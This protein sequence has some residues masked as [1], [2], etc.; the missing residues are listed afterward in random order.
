MTRTLGGSVELLD[1]ALSYTRG[2]LATVRDDVL[3]RP[4]P[5]EGWRLDDLLA[6]MEDALD[7]FTEAAGGA[8]VLRGGS[9]SRGQVAV[10]R[11]KA[12]ALLGAWARPAPGDVVIETATGSRDLTTPLLV[13]TAAL[14]VTVHGW[15]VGQSTGAAGMIPAELARDLLDVA[16]RVVRPADRGSG[17]RPPAGCRRCR[18][19]TCGCWRSSAAADWSTGRLS[20]NPGR[21]SA[22]LPRLSPMPT[23]QATASARNDLDSPSALLARGCARARAGRVA[24]A[25]ADLEQAREVGWLELGEI[26]RVTLLATAL[27]CRLARGDLSLAL[28][29]GD[30]LGAFLDR[31]GIAGATAQFARGELAA[32]TGD[33]D[34]AAGH[35]ARA[36]SMV[37]ADDDPDLLPWRAAAALAAAR[38]GRGAEAAA[39]AREHLTLARATDSPYAVALALRTVATVDVHADRSATLREA[40][41]VLDG[42]P[43]ARLAAQID[44]D[45]A[46]LVLLSGGGADEVLRLLRGAEEYVGREELW[47]L[48]NRIRR[49]LDRL[50][51]PARPVLGEALA[52]LTAAERRVAQL[53]VGGLT[54]REIATELVV[55]VKAVEWHL[56]HVYRKLGIRSRRGLAGVLGVA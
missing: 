36:G 32:A 41:A 11:S 4:T 16:H 49:L 26:E 56:S 13:A 6:H 22:C 1:R 35:F 15:D 10:L 30:E 37:G 20:A 40:R 54:N 34:L 31:P 29:H 2:Q 28:G 43:A 33:A 42:V 50:G 48:Q 7:A 18:R 51:E 44:T 14:E 45:L 19:T 21:T 9:E 47:P 39:L 38:L 53:A 46:G 12:C 27:D 25:L 23:P 17:S 3:G 55:T 52:T 5:C 8:V 24:A